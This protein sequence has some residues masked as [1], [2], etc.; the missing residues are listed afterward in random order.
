[1]NKKEK[2]FLRALPHADSR[3]FAEL[4]A[5]IS[6]PRAFAARQKG[7]AFDMKKHENTRKIIKHAFAG[8]LAA[9]LLCGGGITAMVAMRG[10]DSGNIFDRSSSDVTSSTEAE[11]LHLNLTDQQWDNAAQWFSGMGNNG[12]YWYTASDTGWY[13]Q[14]YNTLDRVNLTEKLSEEEAD[15]VYRDFQATHLNPNNLRFAAY[16]DTASGETVPLCARANCLHSGD[17]FC[18]A[19]TEKYLHYGLVF[20]D[21]VLYAAACDSDYWNSENTYL[22]SYA[23]D[24]TG[25]TVLARIKIENAL[26]V[27]TPVIHRGY[28][29]WIVQTHHKHTGFDT[30]RG[31]GKWNTGYVILGY[32]IA[33]GKT[34]ELYRSVPDPNSEIQYIM[35]DML[36]AGGDWLCYSMSRSGDWH[37]ENSGGIFAVNLVTGEH[38]KAA[39]ADTNFFTMHGST[40]YYTVR[41]PNL[42]CTEQ[43]NLDTGETDQ[44]NGAF[45]EYCVDGRYFY[46]LKHQSSKADGVQ[47]SETCICIYDAG[48]RELLKT[49]SLGQNPM[50]CMTVRGGYFYYALAEGNSVSLRRC[51]LEGLL[52]GTPDSEKVFTMSH[53]YSY[54][55]E[56]RTFHEMTDD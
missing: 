53:E 38:K 34:V 41:T 8:V 11:G 35:P 18:E 42:T 33:T 54:D 13:H 37:I 5:R 44:L 22:L 24:G 3:Y 39:P 31:A 14:L 30:D 7:K 6:A 48:K 17:E 10:R 28:V 20:Y 32:E 56:D 1:M 52:S 49:V 50:R 4:S 25:I 23:P 46:G 12:S 29:W 47:K 43:M 26:P 45:S 2:A 9:A 27:G 15:A 16:S 51:A 36:C 21:G 40:V 55:T 19:S